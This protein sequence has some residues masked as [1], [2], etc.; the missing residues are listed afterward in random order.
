MQ[1]WMILAAV[2]AILVVFLVTLYREVNTVRNTA[3]ELT[4]LKSA[5]PQQAPEAVA[6]D[7]ET[8]A[9]EEMEE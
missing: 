8:I 6:A 9:D 1:A 7:D 3:R 4:P 2:L 5:E